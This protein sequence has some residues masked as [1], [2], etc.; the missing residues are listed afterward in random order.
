MTVGQ[1]TR[2]SSLLDKLSFWKTLLPPYSWEVAGEKAVL[3]VSTK[4]EKELSGAE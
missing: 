1:R 2:S 3:S 4:M